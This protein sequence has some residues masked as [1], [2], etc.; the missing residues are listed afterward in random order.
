MHI[1]HLGS[2]PDLVLLHGWGLN[3]EVWQPVLPQLTAQYRVHLVDLPGFGHNHDAFLLPAD[4]LA[5]ADAIAP[6]LPERYHVLGWSMGG[7]IAQALARYYP[8]RVQSLILTA[9]SPFF[10]KTDSWPGI[11][12]AVLDN[13]HA[14]LQRDV[15]KTVERFLAIQAM[16]SETV[17]ADVK[18]LKQWLAA[19]PEPVFWALN[20]GLQ[21]LK[22]ADLRHTLAKIP[23]PMLGVF[24][25]LD[26]LVPVAAV[27]QMQ[28]LQPA[29]Q[30]EIFEHASHAPFIAE[31]DRFVARIHQFLQQLSCNR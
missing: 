17:K 5:W 1:D 2:G 19:R 6:F 25:R 28:A 15:H 9:S 10:V 30:V 20:A 18:Q 11:E 3:S 26:A 14:G 31:A 13:F 29:M 22:E 21:L 27:P 12:P 4:I 7:L 23:C 16:G 24:G 8:Q